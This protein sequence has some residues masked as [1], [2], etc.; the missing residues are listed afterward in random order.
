MKRFRVQ[1]RKSFEVLFHGEIEAK[2]EK[3]AEKILR[4]SAQ[5]SYPEMDSLDL[6][7]DY[8]SLDDGDDFCIYDEQE[9]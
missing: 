9:T 8:T 6:S 7:C 2:T 1:Y 3:Q 5:D 4:K